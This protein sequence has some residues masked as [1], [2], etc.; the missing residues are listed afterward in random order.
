[1]NERTV[2]QHVFAPDVH[3]LASAILTTNAELFLVVREHMPP[4]A[5]LPRPDFVSAPPPPREGAA[6]GN[7]RKRPRR[8]GP[9]RGIVVRVAR[10]PSRANGMSPT[11]QPNSPWQGR[12]PFAS[13]PVP[14][15]LPLPDLSRFRFSVS[16][17]QTVAGTTDSGFR[18]VGSVNTTGRT[19]VYWDDAGVCVV[20]VQQWNG[21]RSMKSGTFAHLQPWQISRRTTR[22]DFLPWVSS[23]GIISRRQS[24]RRSSSRDR[25]SRRPNWS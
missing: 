15:S 17:T 1:M 9:W 3:C 19:M 10:T 21:S 18:R 2:I 25:A 7:P 20:S 11:D 6:Y 12:H 4:I 8:T 14:L 16:R 5:F 23:L 22:T 24:S 13:G